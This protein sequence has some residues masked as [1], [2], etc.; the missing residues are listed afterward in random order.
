M[1]APVS[2]FTA[3]RLTSRADRFNRP[4]DP[5]RTPLARGL[6]RWAH[7][8]PR[9]GLGRRFPPQSLHG[10]VVF[11]LDGAA[12]FFGLHGLLGAAVIGGGTLVVLGVS[13]P[14]KD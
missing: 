14:R 1:A 10:V 9:I 6:G 3:T 13:G 11:L 2:H 5:R 8:A 4:A 7:F 12:F